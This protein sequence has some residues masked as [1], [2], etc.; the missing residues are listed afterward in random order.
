M[1]Y[2]FL[3]NLKKEKFLE[4]IRISY[5]YFFIF[6]HPLLLILNLYDIYVLPKLIFLRI[7]TLILIF[8]TFAIWIES[9]EINLKLTHLNKGI[10]LLL[11]IAT[12]TTFY[13]IHFR[14]SFYGI[15]MRY[16]GLFTFVSYFLL[17]Y[18]TAN[19]IDSEKKL[20]RLCLFFL[21]SSFF[22]SLYGIFQ[23]FGVEP[24]K[25][26]VMILA[27]GRSNSTFGNP[28]ITGL[29]L[30]FSVLIGLGL[31][32]SKAS[33]W[34]R[35][36]AI[37]FL[38]AISWCLVLTST[39]SAW[40]GCL[41][42]LII[43]IYFLPEK[44]LKLYLGSLLIIIIILLLFFSPAVKGRLGE[45][46]KTKK[47]PD[48]IYIWGSTLKLISDNPFGIALENYPYMF[49]K[50]KIKNWGQ[51]ITEKWRS[52]DKAHNNFLQISSTLG[53]VGALAYL[54]II[55]LLILY[56]FKYMKGNILTTA[57]FSGIIGYLI[58]LQYN[59]TGPSVT[60]FLWIFIGAVF[61]ESVDAYRIKKDL[62]V[63]KI[64]G[65]IYVLLLIIM[66]I[67]FYRGFKPIYADNRIVWANYFNNFGLTELSIKESLKAVTYDSNEDMYYRVLGKGY[68]K[69]SFKSSDSVYYTEAIKALNKAIEIN[70][71]NPLNYLG[72]G[73]IYWS[74]GR[75]FGGISEVEK[76]I[77]YYKQA[78]QIEPETLNA[79]LGL[80]EA[81]DYLGNY[82]LSI[83]EAKKI[84][85]I[86]PRRK[87][88]ERKIDEL[89]RKSR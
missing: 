71:H 37:F 69:H 45:Y 46:F 38:P 9:E 10:I 22:V 8:L 52:T 50:Y 72:M 30:I 28:S 77:G 21:T 44:R 70:P 11:A 75:V 3:K 48:R 76:S 4:Q 26:S 36:A 74:G 62:W 51:L 20:Q 57:I 78:V 80:I 66:A 63:K 29:F 18:L 27:S 43:F 54:W 17:F 13:S 65:L 67:S 64:K 16:D 23:S 15:K 47:L 2:E 59:F 12:L 89:E 42:G 60:P 31:F 85:E 73:D 32:S 1:K 55:V 40:L 79:R 84:L 25:G 87:E 68:L 81:Y 7:S 53:I 5:L 19:I 39:R 86:D 83:E 56:F 34:V 6:L 82:Q 41:A 88:M 24:L 33:N 35:Y 58:G 14:T 49:P 61:Y